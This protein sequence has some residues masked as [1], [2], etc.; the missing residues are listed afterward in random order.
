MKA[1]LTQKSN[2]ATVIEPAPL[3][4][5]EQE[6][7]G[8]SSNS[9]V[10]SQLPTRR[11]RPSAWKTEDNTGQLAAP[12]REDNTGELAAPK[13]ADGTGELTA[14][15]REENT[16][17]LSLPKKRSSSSSDMVVAK[18]LRPWDPEYETREVK[19]VEDIVGGQCAEQILFVDKC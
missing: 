3:P 8:Q 9:N 11:F 13:R 18:K 5:S 12:T 4:D 16:G 6:E 15:K 10:Q 2:D 17:D 1:S 7:G 19:D 14:P